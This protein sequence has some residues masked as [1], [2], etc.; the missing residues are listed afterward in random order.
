MVLDLVADDTPREVIPT[1]LLP[2]MLNKEDLAKTSGFSI[3]T[4]GG[5]EG[6]EGEEAIR[7]DL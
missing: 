7:C 6:D 2:R 3:L 4:D 1:E 5:D